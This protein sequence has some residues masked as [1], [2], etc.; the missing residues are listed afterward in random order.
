MSGELVRYD[1][2]CH[3]IA[4]AYEVDEVKEI[5]DRAAAL[6]H[7]AKQAHNTEAETR[8][9][10]IRLRAERK[11]GELLK[12]MEK[13]KGAAQP[14]DAEPVSRLADHSITPKQSSQ[15]QKLADVSDDQF[16]A[17][18]AGPGKPT[19]NGI[20]TAAFPPKPKPVSD[21]ALW[22]WGTL[23][24]FDTE[25]YLAMHPNDC[26][27]TMTDEML[28]DVRERLPDVIVWLCRL[29]IGNG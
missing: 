17:A 29:E 26:L 8:C 1:A 6:E 7:Y 2:M 10:E 23:N 18:L 19:T 21:E 20:I 15:W 11:T 5:R 14:R 16:E 4:A 13:A 24:D 27:A 9:C 22:L 3:A 28:A 25:G 12:K